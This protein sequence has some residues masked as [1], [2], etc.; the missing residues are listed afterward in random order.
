MHY[1]D[2]KVTDQPTGHRH[3]RGL[4][5]Q[6]GDRPGDRPRPGRK[7]SPGK[8]RTETRYPGREGDSRQLGRR[9]QVGQFGAGTGVSEQPRWYAT[10]PQPAE[11]PERDRPLAAVALGGVCPTTST[12]RAGPA[13]PSCS[14]APIRGPIFTSQ[15]H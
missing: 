1:V 7:P 10:R 4:A 8:D 6:L 15:S 5:F 13:P 11:Q 12:R 3:H 14:C 2:G 9:Q